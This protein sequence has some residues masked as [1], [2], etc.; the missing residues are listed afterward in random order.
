M[1]SIVRAVVSFL[2]L[3]SWGA[4]QTAPRTYVYDAAGNRSSVVNQIRLD[5]AAGLF[6]EPERAMVGER[7]NLY[8]RN[9]PAGQPGQVA[10]VLGGQAATVL[11]VGDRVITVEV[12]A[13]V[14][15]GPTSICPTTMSVRREEFRTSMPEP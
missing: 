2:L 4:A 10:V 14:V 6:V 9:F 1:S 5:A 13:G 15:T 8:G 12:P 3:A 7:M 11:A